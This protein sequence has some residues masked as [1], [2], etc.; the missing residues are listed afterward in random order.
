M[1]IQREW[2]SEFIHLG[3]L[4]TSSSIFVPESLSSFGKVDIRIGTLGCVVGSVGRAYVDVGI[5]TLGC[6]VG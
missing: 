2:L 4:M 1:K 3:S 6:L 5:G